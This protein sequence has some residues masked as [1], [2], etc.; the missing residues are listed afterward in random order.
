MEQQAQIWRRKRPL[1]LVVR[2]VQI[3]VSEITRHAFTVDNDY[4][5]WKY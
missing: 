3:G 1:I 5:E 2:G 4:R